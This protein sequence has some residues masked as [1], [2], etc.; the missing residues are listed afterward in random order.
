MKPRNQL[1]LIVTAGVLGV[2]A[3][4]AGCGGSK[5]TASRSAAEYDAARAK[6]EPVKTEEGH[7]GHSAGE[8]SVAETASPGAPMDHAR[9]GHTTPTSPGTRPGQGSGMA[10]M[11]HATTDE[12]G[13]EHAGMD[14]SSMPTPSTQ[15]RASGRGAAMDHRRMPGMAPGAAAGMQRGS[16]AMDHSRMAES[17]AH[18]MAGMGQSRPAQPGAP[19]ATGHMDHS[20][21]AGPP[22]TA[23][24]AG[25]THGPA[26]SA[27]SMP[28]MQH[29]TMTSPLPEPPARTAAP[30]EPARTLQPDPLDMPTPTAVEEATRAASM[31]TEMAGG[32]AMSHGTYRQLDAGRD[33]G[34]AAPAGKQP[35]HEM[36]QTPMQMPATGGGH[37][38]HSAPA[39]PSS[40]TP[41]RPAT[42]GAT[43][44][45]GQEHQSSRPQSQ[46]SPDPHLHHQPSAPASPSPRPSPTPEESNE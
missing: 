36:N 8:A 40:A 9:M 42:P 39:S 37:Q 17:G 11:D 22:G 7:G 29:G 14:H 35:G 38:M 20:T 15:R 26:T 25:M 13:N 43:P 3:V 10:G 1:T 4:A 27:S 18:T 44:G 21:M 30:A 24:M 12:R 28:A 46:P 19:P 41:S 23:P 5:S 33:Q 6:G 34:T 31:A 2:I 45:P 32:H 16:S